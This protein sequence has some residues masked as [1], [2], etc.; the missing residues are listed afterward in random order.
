[1][2]L[3]WLLSRRVKF[4]KKSMKIAGRKMTALL[5]DSPLKM[6]LGLMFREELKKDE[7]MLFSFPRSGL[8]PFWTRHMRFPIDIVW[9]DEDGKVIDFLESVEPAGRLSFGG[10]HPQKLSRYV[11][12]FNAG[13]VEK[14]RIKVGRKVL[15]P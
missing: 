6:T 8:H 10:H 15:K 14:N 2:C 5:A 1:M 9:C 11:I 7:C 13:F 4:K 3:M 12:E